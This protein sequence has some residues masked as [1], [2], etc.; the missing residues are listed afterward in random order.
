MGRDEMT[1]LLDTNA[2]L[3]GY[4]KQEALPAEIRELLGRPGA[5][6]GLSAISLW[7]VGKKH[8]IGKLEL[9]QE[10]GAWL[11]GALASNIQLLPITPEIVADAM[12]LPDFPVNDPADELIVATAR[13]HR[14]TLLT[15]DTKLKGYRPARIRHFRPLRRKTGNEAG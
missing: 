5:Q 1:W 9:Q 4:S 14:L 2:W 12:S 11:K 8:Q 15:T 10:L 7:E 6:F 3:F 13:V